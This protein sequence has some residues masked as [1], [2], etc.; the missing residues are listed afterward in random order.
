M[1]TVSAYH[2]QSSVLP[3][4]S[5]DSTFVSPT[6]SALDSEHVDANVFYHAPKID[7][8]MVSPIEPSSTTSNFGPALPGVPDFAPGSN[9]ATTSAISPTQPTGPSVSSRPSSSD[10]PNFNNPNGME[11][12]SHQQ[13]PSASQDT[14]YSINFPP[15][16]LP[17]N[18]PT[19]PYPSSQPSIPPSQHIRSA[20][21]PILAVPEMDQTGA[22]DNYMVD[23]Q[24]ISQATK[25]AKWAIS[26][27]NF[28]DVKT[29]VKELKGALECLGVR[30]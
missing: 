13:N 24:A 5:Q 11:S 18:T 20:P 25:H 3:S 23:D 12:H 27:L 17:P 22:G 21:G 8:N 7:D 19:Y 16:H 30:Q 26:A 2:E 15:S 28:E 6:V 10:M 14:R 29:A 4:A 1:P 9:A